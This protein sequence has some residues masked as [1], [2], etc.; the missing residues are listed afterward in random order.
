LIS[1]TATTNTH[2]P[3]WRRRRGSSGR[4]RDDIHGMLDGG[5]PV[6]QFHPPSPARGVGFY[7]NGVGNTLT[8]PLRRLSPWLSCAPH[9]GTE[10]ARGARDG[11]S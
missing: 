11:A 9:D 6:R 2:R 8:P 10:S 7:A 3:R 1:N 5:P 4:G